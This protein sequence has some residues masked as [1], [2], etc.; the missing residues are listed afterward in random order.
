LLK[1][2]RIYIV[3]PS[4]QKLIQVAIGGST[5]AIT[6]GVYDNADLSQSTTLKKRWEVGVAT[7]A[8]AAV[9]SL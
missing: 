4:A 7:N 3:S 2:D 9:I 6:S 5:L 1:N 8:T